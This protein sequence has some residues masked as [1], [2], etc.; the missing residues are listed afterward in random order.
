MKKHLMQ[1]T[2]RKKVVQTSQQTEQP[3]NKYD[4]L[5]PHPQRRSPK[6]NL[7]S[8]DQQF[9]NKDR[10]KMIALGRDG[11]ENAPIIAAIT[12]RHLDL[13]IGDGNRLQMN[14]PDKEL[15][16]QI[17]DYFNKTWALDHADGRGRQTF[18]ELQRLAYCEEY[19]TGDVFAWFSRN[20][21][22]LFLYDANQ[23]VT[24]S[25]WKGKNSHNKN[26]CIDGVVVNGRGRVI[27]YIFAGDPTKNI[28]T[29]D[30]LKFRAEK[31]IHVGK[32]HNIRQVRGISSVLP[33]INTVNKINEMLT[34]ELQSS[35]SA[36]KFAVVVKCKDPEEKSD[37]M[38]NH[39]DVLDANIE[40]AVAQAENGEEDSESNV[41]KLQNY[42]RLEHILGGNVEY[43]EP[44]EDISI[45]ENKRPSP[46]MKEFVNSCIRQIG[47]AAN[48]PLE[49]L[50]LDF[51]N[52][53]FSANRASLM[54]A[55]CHIHNE[56]E[57]WNRCF[58]RPIA[59]KVLQ[60]ACDDG[61]FNLPENWQDKLSFSAPGIPSVDR[62]KDE[63]AKELAFKNGTAT[64][65]D[66]IAK[67]GGQDNWQ[68][69]KDQLLEE[70][71]RTVDNDIKLEI[72]RREQYQAN[73]LEIA[74]PD[75]DTTANNKIKTFF[76]KYFH[77]QK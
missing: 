61:V 22:A 50:L 20:D 59:L 7:K 40:N 12:N 73:N 45:I 38:L 62:W 10:K 46:A 24:P 37:M 17:E 2:A 64:L 42:E 36:A 5:I 32:T 11:F 6:V 47:A 75:D 15:K 74:T 72:Y 49:I 63:K 4:A 67:A 55:W 60:K 13:V 71:K 21:N 69:V 51:S 8:I 48:M 58:N 33:F 43:M 29:K 52:N 31:I 14:I 9:E 57:R 65:Q 53:S 23:C 76:A 3:Q 68:D 77:I 41:P 16:Q 34:N 56:Q 19:L 25:D 39:A 1:K 27:Q 28:L 66:E 26:S 18:Y 54:L 44:G 70:Q 30:A 35:A